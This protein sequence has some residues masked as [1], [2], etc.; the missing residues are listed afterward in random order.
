MVHANMLD[1]FTML[2]PR[3][4]EIVHSE[5]ENGAFRI[6]LKYH[7][8]EAVTFVRTAVAP[9]TERY[10][11]LRA[12]I[13]AMSSMALKAGQTNIATL[14]LDK[15]EEQRH[16]DFSVFKLDTNTGKMTSLYEWLDSFEDAYLLCQLAMTHKRD[17]EIIVITPGSNKSIDKC[18]DLYNRAQAL[19]RHVLRYMA[20]LDCEDDENNE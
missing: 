10:H 19:E 1:I 16:G 7:N 3:G 9:G 6:Q 2:L 13:H 11:C 15:L 20:S 18:P 14:W 5:V 4:V 12:V 17:C 8:Q